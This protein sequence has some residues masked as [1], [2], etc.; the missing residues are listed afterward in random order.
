MGRVK[1]QQ[2]SSA[3]ETTKARQDSNRGRAA[4]LAIMVIVLVVLVVVVVTANT[5]SCS[6]STNNGQP[7][8]EPLTIRRDRVPPA[9]TADRASRKPVLGST[10][11]DERLSVS[12]LTVHVA[13]D[14]GMPV[15]AFWVSARRLGSRRPLKTSS[16][17]RIFPGEN[18][19]VLAEELD[20]GQWQF[21]AHTEE[22]GR[23]APVLQN[24]PSESR[25]LTIVV[26]RVGGIAGMVI[27]ESGLP[28]V[29]A[30]IYIIS[31]GEDEP[32]FTFGPVPQ[33]RSAS[34]RDGRFRVDG[35]LPGSMRTM[36]R[37]ADYCEGEWVESVIRPGE[38]VALVLV[39]TDGGR[40]EG[41]VDPNIGNVD[42]RAIGLYSYRAGRGWR[43]SITD[44]SGHFTIEHAIPQA[45]VIELR[46]PGD[47]TREATE[48]PAL[49]QEILVHEG[50]TTHV[51]FGRKSRQIVL[52]GIL[53]MAGNP[54]TGLAISCYSKDNE[55]S[56]VVAI[57]DLDGTFRTILNGPGAYT[58]TVEENYGSVAHFDIAVADSNAVDVALEL[59]SSALSG[60][61]VDEKMHPLANVP[62]TIVRDGA[63][64]ADEA[65]YR[66]LFRR[67][68]S[69]SDGSFMFALLSSGSY[70]IR[71]PD[72]D[73]EE[74][75][76]PNSAWGRVV[77]P[78][79][80]TTPGE[81]G[82]ICL[83]LPPGSQ[84][85]GV[86]VGSDG[87]PIANAVVYVFGRDGVSLSAEW[88][89][90]T[91][92]TGGFWIGNVSPGSYTVRVTTPE[93][94]VVSA[95]FVVDAARVAYVVIKVP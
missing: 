95:P 45:Y 88:A 52:S 41:V 28:I 90:R 32:D 31:A 70:T 82:S 44:E 5:D 46:P 19:K 71:A 34:G 74:S 33:P 25:V 29:D 49:R 55:N 35:V 7:G 23:S 78:N 3:T 47:G 8:L 40:I 14:V 13:D 11:P 43:E 22:G 79:V 61:V 36:A 9:S 60:Q 54:A 68:W 87:L 84:V 27:G 75:P 66:D 65:F 30:Q 93:R 59:P 69:S 77:V 6:D 81:I 51:V 86:V 4:L 18:G 92:P 1:P 72:G 12:T 83:R 39:L 20:P 56:E 57:S 63:T 37:H 42:G 50:G 15:S 53:T 38:T 16:A 80:T 64:V 76:R 17:E 91:D 94:K 26:S 58:L 48:E 85:T 10:P 89:A 2:S 67:H 24:V 62:I 73:P 21:T